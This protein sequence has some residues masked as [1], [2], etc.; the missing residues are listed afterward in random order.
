VRDEGGTGLLADP[1]DDVEDAVGQAGV[2]GDVGE[3]RPGEGR[4]LR[5]LEDDGVGEISAATPAG[6][7]ETW[8]R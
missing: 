6:S 4:P 3:Q 1:L 8:L 7:Y 5:R 2:A